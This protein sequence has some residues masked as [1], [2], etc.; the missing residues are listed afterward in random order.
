MIKEFHGLAIQST[1]SDSAYYDSEEHDVVSKRKSDSLVDTHTSY[2]NEIKITDTDTTN[3]NSPHKLILNRI[4]PKIIPGTIRLIDQTI[5]E[6]VVGTRETLDARQT[7]LS[8]DI[9]TDTAPSGAHISGLL[10]R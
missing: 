1:I 6:D 8:E 10:G 4:S 5:T 7:V 9:A 2:G 3:V